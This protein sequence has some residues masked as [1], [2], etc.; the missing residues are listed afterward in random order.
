[1][2]KGS[3]IVI[4][5]DRSLRQFL[6]ILLRRNG[7]SVR[8]AGGGEEG[9]ALM[10]EA[11]AD[12]VI[13]DL[14]MEG[15]DGMDVLRAVKSGWPE[16][17]VMMVTAFATT[18]NAV[19]AMK[20]GAFDYVTKPF[21]VDELKLVLAKAFEQR[22]MRRENRALKRMLKERFTYGRLIGRSPPML[23]LYDLVERVKDTPVTVL[24]TGESGT[25]KELV[26]RAIH[27]QGA[28]AEGPFRSINCGAIPENLIEAE[29][30]GYKKGAFTGAVR[31]HEGLFVSG[32]G[33]TVFLDEVGEMPLHTQV[34]VLRVLQERRVKA[35]GGI[36]ERKVDVRIVAATNRDLAE[37]VRAGRFREDLYYR[38]RVVTVQLPPLRDRLT[39]LPLLVEHFVEHYCVEFGRPQLGVSEAAMQVLA[40]HEWPG[41]VR[42]LENV[43][44][45]GVALCQGTEIDLASLPAEVVGE[46]LV[47]TFEAGTLPV[48]VGAEG[49]PL[50]RTLEDYER[51]LLESALGTAG[52]VKKDA[53]KLLGITFRSFRYRLQ[54]LG[55]EE[56]EGNAFP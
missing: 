30:F 46:R 52:G 5:D 26:A 25:G 2:G 32:A 15:L 13:T 27:N 42:E 1:M 48:H 18:K 34:K 40:A 51:L 37:E 24:V 22:A 4:D 56:V 54:K 7:Y 36:D 23:A 28:R 11:V 6:M 55:L 47:Q 38:L 43:I 44:Q 10:K 16:T 9:L 21:N 49:L 17:E 19:E 29:L 3:V 50:E 31:D 45:R 20:E 8:I 33:G 41:N 12:V 53:A 39:D 14:N 35:V